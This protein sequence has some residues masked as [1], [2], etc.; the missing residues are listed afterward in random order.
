MRRQLRSRL[1]SRVLYGIDPL[2][3]PR[4]RMG[5]RFF[6]FAIATALATF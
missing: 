3:C 2:A 5:A 6:E 1:A 4:K